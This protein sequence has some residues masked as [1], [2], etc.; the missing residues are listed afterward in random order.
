VQRVIHRQEDRVTKRR[1]ATAALLLVLLVGSP[2]STAAVPT[3]STCDVRYP[4]DTRVPWVCRVLARGETAERLF[5]DRWIDVLRFNRIDRRHAVAGAALKVPRRLR[6]VRGFTPMPAIYGEAT[7]DAKFV[8]IDLT[9]Q[10]LGAYEQGRLAF[11][12]PL[13]TGD[14]DHPTPTGDFTV[15]A[16]HRYHSSSL[17]TIEA[18]GV[19]YPMTWALRFHI[20]REGVSSWLH[21]RD[22]PGYPGSHG[23]IGLY[24]E[25]MQQSYYGAP[26]RPVLDDARRLYEWVA[27]AG[28]DDSQP[29]TI[30]GPRLRIMGS[31]SAN[32]S[33]GR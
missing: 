31:A 7:G 19:P 2:Y 29:R 25:W 13:S 32:R 3:T 11:S 14:A 10:F 5:G 27:G 30:A 1:G 17:Y 24:D 33:A 4:S 8:L 23:C 16:A 21:G 28:A 20:T 22:V 6:D 15:T 18:T 12:S 26:T 9:E